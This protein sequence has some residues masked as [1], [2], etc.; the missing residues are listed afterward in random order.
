MFVLVVVFLMFDKFDLGV[1]GKLPRTSESQGVARI[2]VGRGGLGGSRR[3]GLALG[4]VAVRVRV[5]GGSRI[6]RGW[7]TAA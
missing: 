5:A 4:R 2:Q 7:A 3:S 6:A 1:W